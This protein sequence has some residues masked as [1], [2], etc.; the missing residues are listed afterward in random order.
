MGE[1]G[2]L[3]QSEGGNRSQP[4]SGGSGIGSDVI[5]DYVKH[6]WRLC[7]VKDTLYVHF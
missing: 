5:T 4:Q 7:T 3:S 6:S 1:L 2:E